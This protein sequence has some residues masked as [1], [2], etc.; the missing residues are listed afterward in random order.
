MGDTIPTE[1]VQV[2]MCGVSGS[3][4]L[5]L[6]VKIGRNFGLPP[7]TGQILN[8]T[9]KKDGRIRRA[10]SFFDVFFDIEVR[11]PGSPSAIKV[12]NITPARLDALPAI[13][14]LPPND[15]NCDSLDTAYA[16]EVKAFLD[17]LCE[18]CEDIDGDGE[19]DDTECD[20]FRA[21]AICDV[22]IREALH[23]PFEEE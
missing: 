17:L 9:Q 10:D 15:P 18:Q 14:C 22:E 5:E 2:Q 21:G 13:D 6:K 12:K 11:S 16:E 8:I 3:L 4:G 19:F 23:A 1:I 7:S 20:E